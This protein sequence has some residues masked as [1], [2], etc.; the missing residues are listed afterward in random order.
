VP[1]SGSSDPEES[2]ARDTAI[3]AATIC[4]LTLA[5]VYLASRVGFE[6]PLTPVV[7]VA[8]LALFH[9]AVPLIVS[10]LFAR[11]WQG[12][13][14]TSQSLLTIAS[15][16]L[17]VVAGA[18][19]RATG[20]SIAPLLSLSGGLLAGAI[21][22]RWLRHARFLSSAL[23]V[24]GAGIFSLWLA[25][26]V[27]G[28]GSNKTPLF[29]ETF[30]FSATVHQDAFYVA[31]IANM[32][33]TYGVAS[34]GI[35]GVP[36][37]HWHYGSGWMFAQWAD[38]IGIDV[39]SFYNLGYPI[40]VIPLFFAALV[41]LAVE[42]ARRLPLRA[43]E[44]PLRQQQWVW[45]VIAAA[46]IGIL[47]ERALYRL[48]TVWYPVSESYLTGLAVFLLAI[49]TAVSY[50]R[51]GRPH[52]WGFCLTFVPLTLAALGFLKVSLMILLFAAGL[53]FVARLGLWRQ[54]TVLA[55][56]FLSL[57]MCILVYRVVSLPDQNQGISPLAFVRT[58]VGA[59][60]RPFF[61]LFHFA[62][63]WIFIWARLWEE[64]LKTLAD[65]KRAIP[66]G[67]LLDAEIVF[68]VA[69]LG[70][71]PG[72]ILD[73]H[74]G[75]AMFF[76][77]VQRWLALGL[78]LGRV[79]FWLSERKAR[80]QALDDGI[81][82]GKPS[83]LAGLR[84]STVLAAVIVAPFGVTL[85]LNTIRPP[86]EM[87]RSNVTLRRSLAKSSEKGTTA[88]P[89]LL[90]Y[91]ADAPLLAAGLRRAPYYPLVTAL[92]EINDL[93]DAQ[94]RRSAL[95]IPQ[96]YK[97]FWT[98]LPDSRCVFA[99]LVAPAFSGVALIDGMPPRACKITKQ[100]NMPVYQAR[101]REQTPNDVTPRALCGNALKKGF[102]EV[103]V[104]E[105]DSAGMPR[106][107]RLACSLS[108]SAFRRDPPLNPE[109]RKLVR[110]S[111]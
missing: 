76:S 21:I 28:T 14:W 86:F 1:L 73:I 34:T 54:R 20:Y 56:V 75:S 12:R 29:W 26:E 107:R 39:M 64:R 58:Y 4:T 22:I 23:F 43:F 27:W 72:E 30:S 52:T 100:Y 90:R 97:Q 35:D 5:A 31:A 110:P 94:K 32:M 95:F 77:D 109:G 108:D 41:I 82:T 46:T 48:T 66:S 106:R 2:D 55:S 89:G 71:L 81:G 87:A 42:I 25:G 45:I 59:G 51:T 79:N 69:L 15:L 9:L 74:G 11:V 78:I 92:R 68:L 17:T 40:V 38:L 60:W 93:P 6:N 96:S 18:V 37:I 84:V 49:G 99:P 101:T 7:N 57:V 44:Q 70:F 103:L 62:W 50:W 19:A 65:L 36:S 80:Q 105:S 85:V 111:N 10:G 13:W 83:G 102:S 91:V 104:L 47:P 61:P 98:M 33:R 63:S 3:V 88:S 67:R 8:G 53:Y 16:V 24:I